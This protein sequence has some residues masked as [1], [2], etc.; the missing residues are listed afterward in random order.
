MFFFS[1]EGLKETDIF[2]HD[3]LST[4]GL[5]ALSI[6][7]SLKS[8]LLEELIST[9]QLSTKHTLTSSTDVSS[10]QF[11]NFDDHDTTQIVQST[12]SV[13]H[14][15]IQTSAVAP[16]FFF[17]NRR[18][19][20]S[21]IISLMTD[22][23]FPTKSVLLNND[24]DIALSAATMSSVISGIPETYAELNRHSFLS[25]GLLLTTAS[26]SIS[27]IVSRGAQE[28]TEE[29]LIVTLISRRQC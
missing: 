18:E 12:T 22:F 13:S 2:K 25:P 29:Y 21:F 24:Q 14:M 19:R 28:D 6:G 26:M 1:S 10:S 7:I 20:I 27:S 8:Y 3:V 4:I 15:P 11:L 23:I 17:F 9:R 5:S 16:G